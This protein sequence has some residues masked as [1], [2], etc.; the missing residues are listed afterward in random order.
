MR[1]LSLASGGNLPTTRSSQRLLLLAAS[2]RKA[3]CSVSNI[4]LDPDSHEAQRV[5]RRNKTT[6]AASRSNSAVQQLSKNQAVNNFSKN[7]EQFIN[8]E[9]KH[10]S[11]VHRLR[12]I[13]PAAAVSPS[14]YRHKLFT[15]VM[16]ISFITK[17]N[18]L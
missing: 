3:L 7:D 11:D 12:N 13:T 1:R 16:Q 5:V 15:E 18:D 8:A 9:F 6:L 2:P 17:N 4:L 10:G 14:K